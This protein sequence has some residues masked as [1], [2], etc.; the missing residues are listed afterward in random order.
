M[1]NVVLLKTIYPFLLKYKKNFVIVLALLPFIAL[2]TAV[3]PYIFKLIIDK[4]NL[5]LDI[6]I[7][8]WLLI[9]VALGSVSL[10]VSQNIIIQLIGQ[11]LICDIRYT[12]FEHLQKLKISFFHRNSTGKI[13]TR[14]TNDL[15]ALNETLSSGLIGAVNDLVTIIALLAFMLYMNWQL[16]LIIMC[17]I[18]VLALLLQTFQTMYRKASLASREYLAQLNGEF[19]QTLWGLLV[20]KL[21]HAED[22][23]IDK[24]ADIN[25]K[26]IQSNNKYIAIDASF[27]AIV[28]FISIFSIISVI[29]YSL[30]QSINMTTGELI[31]FIGYSQ[32]LFQ[33]VQSLSEKFGILQSSLTAIQKVKELLDEP[34]DE[35][36]L[37]STDDNQI[38]SINNIKF[39]NISFRYSEDTD[40]VLRDI[41]FELKKGDSLGIVGRTGSGKSTLV[42]LLT[43]LYTATHGDILLNINNNHNIKISEINPYNIRKHILLIPQKSFLFSGSILENLLLDKQ[44]PENKIQE[45]CQDTGLLNIINQLPNK[46]HTLIQEGGGDLSN[47]QK[48]LI[49][50]TR[51]IIQDPDILILDE[52]TAE[53]DTYTEQCIVK[54]TKKIINS[55]KTII[56]I[57]HKM[58]LVNECNNI[59]A[60]KNG[61]IIES[62][63]HSELMNISDGYYKYLQQFD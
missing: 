27:S 58:Q 20:I 1:Q 31:A 41:N 48:Q 10:Q 49:A 55:N 57:A 60:F 24:F 37:L 5:N 22:N 34:I 53:L 59:L 29:T 9:I 50:L 38:Q 54:T 2:C 25:K 23:F 32:L 56:F 13:L 3:Q 62:G 16:T 44:V 40:Y 12:L 51:S 52:A 15:E 42:K 8:P 30:S 43:S 19:Q 33:P 35:Q 47:G 61:Q 7:L 17:L 63:T 36:L 45:I 18:C 11:K 26:Y 39:Q 28:E 14:L 4:L 6:N 21:F 46:L